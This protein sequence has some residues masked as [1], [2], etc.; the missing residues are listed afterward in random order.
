MCPPHKIIHML[1]FKSNHVN[2]SKRGPRVY[3]IIL[4]SPVVAHYENRNTYQAQK[5]PPMVSAL[6]KKY[7]LIT[8]KIISILSS[9]KMVPKDYWTLHYCDVIMGTIASQITSLTIVY[10]TV[11]SDADQ[12]KHQ[13]SASLAFVWGIHRGPVNSPH[14]WPVTRKMFPFDDVIMDKIMSVYSICIQNLLKCYPP[15]VP[16]RTSLQT[17]LSFNCVVDQTSHICFPYLSDRFPITIIW[18]LMRNEMLLP[19]DSYPFIYQESVRWSFSLVCMNKARTPDS[20]KPKC[21]HFDESVFNHGRWWSHFR[22][23]FH[24]RK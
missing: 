19:C 7:D 11:Y 9:S 23:S 21:C 14:K 10:S 15:K 4:K 20:R 18:E 13:S 5:L 1:G 6:N 3:L 24:H 17:A 8:S 2:K 12:R 16:Q 22:T